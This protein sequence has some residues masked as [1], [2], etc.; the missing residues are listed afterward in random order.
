MGDSSCKSENL[1]TNPTNPL[2]HV[3]F[4]DVKAKK[5]THIE[6][7]TKWQMVIWRNQF[8]QPNSSITSKGSGDCRRIRTNLRHFSGGDKVWGTENQLY[9]ENDGTYSFFGRGL[10]QTHL[11]WHIWKMKSRCFQGENSTENIC[12]YLYPRKWHQ[13]VSPNSSSEV[14]G[15]QVHANEGIELNVS[16]LPRVLRDGGFLK[17]RKSMNI[18]MKVCSMHSFNKTG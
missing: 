13:K 9:V 7:T 3:F 15:Q 1:S 6:A 17:R 2:A 18:L 10:Q 11:K 14:H 8:T 12:C 16:C 5:F 4:F